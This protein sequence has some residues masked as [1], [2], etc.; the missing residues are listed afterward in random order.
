MADLGVHV[1]ETHHLM[2]NLVTRGF[3]ANTF[4]LTLSMMGFAGGSAFSSSLSY[5]LLT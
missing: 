3:S 1:G 4:L 2:A 5:S